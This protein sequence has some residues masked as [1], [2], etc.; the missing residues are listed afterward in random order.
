MITTEDSKAKTYYKIQD[1]MKRLEADGYY[2][3][4]NHPSGKAVAS[5]EDENLTR[6]FSEEIKGF[7]GHVIVNNGTYA[8]IDTM[9]N[10]ENKKPVDSSNSLYHGS[11]FQTKVPNNK[12]PW[13]NIKILSKDDITA[14]MYNLKND[15]NYSSLIL[16][17][18]S[19][20]LN[21]IIDIP[22]TFFN[23]KQEQVEGYIKNVARQYGAVEAFIAT[24]NSDVYNKTLDVT[25]LMDSVLYENGVAEN[26]A[27]LNRV[28]SMKDM[29]KAYRVA[30][31]NVPYEATT[32]SEGNELTKE[33]QERF[34]DSKVRDEQ[35]RLLVLHHG[36]D[37]DFSEFKHEFIGD[38][39]KDGLGFYFTAN[40][41]QFNY[42]YPKTVYLNLVNPATDGKLIDKI[43]R[44]EDKLF[45][46]GFGKKEILQIIQKEFGVDGIIDSSRGNIVAFNS[47]QIKSIDNKTPTDNPDI[48][49]EEE[50]PYNA[51]TKEE[52]A[53]RVRKYIEET[54]KSIGTLGAKVS[55]KDIVNRII[56]NY[57]ITTRGNSKELNKVSKEI[58]DLILNG[59]LTDGKIEGY[60]EQLID[61]LKVTID[62]Y[63]NANKELKEL[64]RRTKLYVSDEVKA[65]FGDFNDFKKQNIGNIRM[66]N[67]REAMPVDTFYQ[68]LAEVY[69][70]TFFPS[71]IANASDQLEK[72]AEVTSQI[73]KIDKSLR[74]NIEE[75]FGE[76]ARKEIVNGLIE[77]FKTLREKASEPVKEETEIPQIKER[78][79]TKTARK[80]EMVDTFLKFDDLKYVVRSNKAT[81]QQANEIL[82]TRGYEDSLKHFEA[83]VESGKFPTVDD[84]ALGERLIQEAI[85]QGDFEKATEIISDVAIL[86]TEL[87]Q[88]VQAMSMIRRLSPAGQLMYL[89]R[90]IRRIN[91]K[92]KT[93][94]KKPTKKKQTG[95]EKVIDEGKVGDAEIKIPDNLK[96]EILSAQTPED[97]QKAVDRAKEYIASQLPVTITEKLTEWRYLAM[98]G[99]PKTHVRNTLGNVVMQAPYEIKNFNQRVLETMFD[100]QLEERTATFKKATKVVKDFADA[101]IE[102]NRD[103]LAGTGYTNIQS[104]LRNMR[105]IYKSKLINKLGE[106]NSGWLERE[107][108]FFKKRTFRNVLAEYLTANKIKTEADIK[109]NPELVQKAIN[110]AIEE[111]KKATFNQYNAVATAI[112]RFENSS[113]LGKVLVGG[114]APFKRTPLNIVKTTW[115]YSPAGLVGT[116]IKQ[117]GNLKNGLITP[118]EYIERISQGLTGT[119]I[120]LIGMLLASLGLVTGSL[121]SK[122]KD[123]YEQ[124]IGLETPYSFKFPWSDKAY[125]ISWI[126]PSAVPL[127]M[128]VEVYSALQDG[129]WLTMDDAIKVLEKTMNP[130]SK[131]TMLS[132]IDDALINYGGDDDVSG[133]AGIADTVLKSY[134]GQAFP[135]FGNQINRIIDP[136]IRSTATSKNS[137]FKTGETLARQNANKIVGLSY[138]LEPSLDIW[139][140]PR[141]RNDNVIIR[142]TDALINPANVTKDTSTDVDHEIL[143]LYDINGDNDIIPATPQKYFTANS[144]KYEFS[145]SEYT[146]YRVTYGQT[147]YDNLEKLFSSSEYKKMSDTD[148]EKAIKHIYDDA[149]QKAKLE[150]LTNRYGEKEGMERL[151]S[152]KDL[153]KVTQAKEKIG[154][155]YNTY[156][157]GYY[158]QTGVE[159]EKDKNGKTK[160]GTKKKNQ[161]EAIKKA[162]PNLTNKQSEDLYK[163][164]NGSL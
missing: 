14:L 52:R 110:Y 154:I 103:A 32:D 64:I 85:K 83:V 35:G 71:D 125:D 123:K 43:I 9:F 135:T 100:A 144:E 76:E 139:G 146:Q 156:L 48:L 149:K 98:L 50:T 39:N 40:E 152:E 41:L 25:N 18:S 60:A 109:A 138:L 130:V 137:K 2:L 127:L 140:N 29:K 86:G 118:N 96:N 24:N 51:E 116:L 66:T 150:F 107:D 3:V 160:S 105:K 81:A 46:K 78:S 12:V 104:E 77:N 72:I 141:K 22:N 136:T 79:W 70:E 89:E 37:V 147:S 68:E 27:S 131:M 97:L 4:H 112:S 53:E 159:G 11:Q 26:S 61:N 45:E 115:Q 82:E 56:D 121:G 128:G 69:G 36:T 163:I 6:Q 19:G 108:F 44:R 93:K 5:K 124:S 57:G 157:K 38:D 75:N 151:L 20:N 91:D 74:E 65:G 30:E 15:P 129:E 16:R 73:K 153:N 95:L 111:A 28:F 13:N 34:K 7:K 101:M 59:G 117:T 142:A 17:D 8:F 31:E 132:T 148:K 88:S 1:R 102:E 87:G 119:G 55:R 49:K 158:A 143:R 63:Y 90:A 161:I 122:K 120:A 54:Q 162:L 126:S 106:F 94:R 155:D 42:D 47:N 99:N 58:Q 134:I 62:D 21:A 10:T 33:Q 145:A 23:M 92:E 80:N 113:S 67:D 164:Y 114:I 133:L 84:I